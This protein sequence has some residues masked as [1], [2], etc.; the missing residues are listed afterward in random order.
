MAKPKAKREKSAENTAKSGV[1]DIVF[2]Q[3][4]QLDRLEELLEELSELG[5]SSVAE[6]E[7]RISELEARIGDTSDA[8]DN[9]P[10]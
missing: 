2:E 7:G 4:L 8:D 9:G 10:V 3:M 1:P 5:I 6:L